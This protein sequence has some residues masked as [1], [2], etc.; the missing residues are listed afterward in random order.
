M[1][2]SH[3][4]VVCAPR[5]LCSTIDVCTAVDEDDGPRIHQPNAQWGF[6]R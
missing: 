2:I 5:C 1:N 3:Y 4:C 6:V